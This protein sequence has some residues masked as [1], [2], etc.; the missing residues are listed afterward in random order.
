MAIDDKK[1]QNKTK[2]L[3]DFTDKELVNRDDFKE[4]LMAIIQSNDYLFAELDDLL[5]Q[6]P[7]MIRQVADKFKID[8]DKELQYEIQRS[9][10]EVRNE[11]RMTALKNGKNFDLGFKVISKEEERDRM[12]ATYKPTKKRTAVEQIKIQHV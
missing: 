11:A 12:S 9:L 10:T 2:N 4:H 7:Y 3:F 6:L 5:G 8:K 1:T